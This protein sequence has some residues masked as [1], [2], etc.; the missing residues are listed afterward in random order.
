ML[1]QSI[2]AGSLASRPSM[3]AWPVMYCTRRAWPRRVSETRSR[4]AA[5]CAV[6]MPGTTSTGDPGGA[7]GGE[8]FVGAAEDHRIAALEPH[9]AAAGFGERDHQRVDVVLPARDFVPGL[10]D[11][12]FLGFAAREIENVGGDQI[13][14]QD[15]VG[16]L[17][18]AHGAQRQQFRIARAGADE[19]DGARFLAR[20][21]GASSASRSASVGS[22]SGAATARAVN[23]SQKPRRP[24]NGRASACTRGRQARA[25]SAQRPK[26]FG[27]SASI[28]A[29]I[30]WPKTGAAPSVEMPMTSGERLTMAP[31]AKSQN[32][33]RSMTLTGTPAARAAAAKAAA[34]SSSAQSATAMAA[35]AISASRPAPLVDDDL[36]ARRRRSERAQFLVGDRQRTHR[37]ARPR[38]RAVRLSRSPPGCRRRRRRACSPARRTPAAAPAGPCGWL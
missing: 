36:A 34:S 7:A 27:I 1:D 18:R 22:R 21:A 38:P 4:L 28:L 31:K 13:V 3:V 29:R 12:H 6:V 20:R 9:H 24:R 11:Q 35:P 26:P 14:E 16:R 19:D 15:H 10:A 25:A 30:A 8:L 32:A 17:Q 23:F 2:S 33:G 5:P 37:R